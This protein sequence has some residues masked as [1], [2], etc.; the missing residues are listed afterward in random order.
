MFLPVWEA[1]LEDTP[2]CG[3]VTFG[4]GFQ[5]TLSHSLTT[6]VEPSW[7]NLK[8]NQPAPF[9]GSSEAPRGEVLQEQG[10]GW[11]VSAVG[12][13][14]AGT[15]GRGLTVP[16]CSPAPLCLCGEGRAG[17]ERRRAPG[18]A[19]GPGSPGRTV[20]GLPWEPDDPGQSRVGTLCADQQL[21]FLHRNPSC[22]GN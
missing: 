11:G 1:G 18:S 17:P 15:D 8:T 7:N 6:G 5:G 10:A 21:G 19:R 12:P 9:R 2:A 16:G 20:R 14:E 4:G 13:R 3:T 22:A